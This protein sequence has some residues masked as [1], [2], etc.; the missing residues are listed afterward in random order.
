LMPPVLES[1]KKGLSEHD[2]HCAVF[3]PLLPGAAK[4]CTQT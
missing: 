3:F 4:Y 1:D 2:T